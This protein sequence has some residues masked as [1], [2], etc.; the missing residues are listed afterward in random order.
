ML[1]K[2]IKYDF[3]FS[4]TWFLIMAAA[5]IVTAIFSRIYAAPRHSLGIVRD[6]DS[7][8]LGIVVMAAGII[9]IFQVPILFNRYL[10]DD[11][12]ILMLT[13]P[14]KRFTLLM[15]KLMVSIVWF[16][17]ML[18][19]AIASFSIFDPPSMGFSF[20]GLSRDI[21]F[22]NFV[23]L[24]EVNI[25]AASLILIIFF[26]STF[27]HIR[28]WR[29]HFHGL[30][31]VA[32]LLIAGLLYWVTDMI[33]SRHFEWVPTT[34]EHLPVPRYNAL[35]EYMGTFDYTTHYVRDIGASVGRI[36]I[37]TGGAFFDI[38]GYGVMVAFIVLMLWATN[39]LL[40]KRVCI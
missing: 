26:S 9:S 24:I 22:V 32:G 18:L 39:Y 13:L 6:A 36:P 10:F 28:L 33:F 20:M 1:V 15:S 21:S 17:F 8:M 37:G 31:L 12:G 2:T 40:S 23:A 30:A 14:V 11:T 19:V 7:I 35:G 16:N 27:A 4:K 5:M 38:Y 34:M 25:V 3:M 29:W